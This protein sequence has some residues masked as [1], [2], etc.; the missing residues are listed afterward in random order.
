MTVLGGWLGR[1][2]DR[3]FHPSVG[4]AGTE[5]TA[6]IMGVRH[7]IKNMDIRLASPTIAKHWNRA[8]ILAYKF[9]GLDLSV[10]KAKWWETSWWQR[11]LRLR[12]GRHSEPE[13]KADEWNQCRVSRETLLVW[14]WMIPPNVKDGQQKWEE[15]KQGWEEQNQAL[16]PTVGWLIGNELMKDGEAQA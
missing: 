15:G 10:T 8:G 7:C 3:W 9:G 5:L 2:P 11:E 13:N 16:L 6:R 1:V 14:T 4:A 12:R